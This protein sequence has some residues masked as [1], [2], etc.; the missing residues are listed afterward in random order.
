MYKNTSINDKKYKKNS[1]ASCCF[2]EANSECPLPINDLNVVG[3]IPWCQY[4]FPSTTS[5]GGV[6]YFPEHRPWATFA[7]KNN[8]FN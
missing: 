2:F 4:F 7:L 6:E 5:V 1:C 8:L 3:L